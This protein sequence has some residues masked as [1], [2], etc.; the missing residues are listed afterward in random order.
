MVSYYPSIDLSRLTEVVMEHAGSR[1]A[2]AIEAWLANFADWNVGRLPIGPEASGPLG[3]AFLAGVDAQ[4]RHH[5]L[6]FERHTDDFRFFLSRPGEWQ[7]ALQVACGALRAVGLEAHKIKHIET[8]AIAER[9]VSDRMIER[10]KWIGDDDVRAAAASVVLLDELER[11]L[12]TRPK[13]IRFAL[14]IL[15]ARGDERVLRRLQANPKWLHAE[16]RAWGRFLA[17]MA[18]QGKT[19]LDW[20]L[21]MSQKGLDPNAAIG[22]DPKAAPGGA[23]AL[24]ALAS[25][26]V[27]ADFADPLDSIAQNMDAPISL[28]LAAA[29]AYG[30]CG[31]VKAH[32][33]AER[34]LESGSNVLKRAYTLTLRH[35][36]QSR[37]RSKALR[38]LKAHAG[39]CRP[40][41]EWIE[42]RS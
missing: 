34:A 1:V 19:D 16:P 11:G 25:K 18:E 29:E 22:V 24:R 14:A 41:V 12:S 8:R 4:L 40:S 30:R 36:S 7:K 28:R 15:T 26:Q 35:H 38:R 21:Q 17:A 39:I 10:L 31:G 23:A 5:G 42:N 6:E 9:E 13:R 27:P 2:S 3:T 32:H 37:A 20:L 33:C